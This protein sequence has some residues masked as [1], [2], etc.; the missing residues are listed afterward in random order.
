[1]SPPHKKPTLPSLSADE[2]AAGQVIF[3][4]GS[5]VDTNYIEQGLIAAAPTR[6][7]ET[8]TKPKPIMD[9]EGFQ[10]VK[11][12]HSITSIDTPKESIAISNRF[13]ALQAD[14]PKNMADFNIIEHE[15]CDTANP[16]KSRK[17]PR[18]LATLRANRK[19]AKQNKKHQKVIR[20]AA[21]AA[22]NF[23]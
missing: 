20:T 1:M 5:T 14:S 13:A 3:R 11:G 6:V 7:M 2:F 18:Y 8:K 16:I 17:S 23:S 9:S 15:E 22:D 19:R 12:S 21:R 10:L 4:S